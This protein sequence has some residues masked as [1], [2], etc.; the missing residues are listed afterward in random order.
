[1]TY[2]SRLA[3]SFARDNLIP[4]LMVVAGV[5]ILAGFVLMIATRYKRCPSNRILV[6]YGKT[7]AGPVLEVPRTAAAPSSGR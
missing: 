2:A 3:Q 4:V 6:I 1:M 7:E 5:I